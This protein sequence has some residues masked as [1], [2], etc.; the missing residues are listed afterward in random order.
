MFLLTFNVFILMDLLSLT[1]IW[2]WNVIISGQT[3]VWFEFLFGSAVG[4]VSG[5]WVRVWFNP[6][7]K[8][9][10][11]GSVK[12]GQIQSCSGQ[13]SAQSRFG[14]CGSVASYYYVSLDFI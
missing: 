13:A 3:Q 9:K 6:V 8:L 2:W 10:V 5:Q 4:R 12:P 11:G 1:E 7:R 14:S